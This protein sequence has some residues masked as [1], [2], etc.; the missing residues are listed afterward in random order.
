M[1]T[2]DLNLSIG[3]FLTFALLFVFVLWI[4]YNYKQE[5]NLQ[6]IQKM[7]QCPFCTYIFFVYSKDDIVTCPRCQSLVQKSSESQAN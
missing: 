6:D 3:L 2:L 7:H 4:F 1:I 5:D